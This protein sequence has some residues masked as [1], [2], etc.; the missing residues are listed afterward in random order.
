VAVV[1]GERQR[2]TATGLEILPVA[3]LRGFAADVLRAVGMPPADA[4]VSATA[5]TW[6]DLRALDAHGVISKLPQCVA[7]IRA[8][9]TAAAPEMEI[10]RETPGA[11]TLDA[12]TGWGQVAAARAMRLAIEKARDGGI[13]VVSVR[14]S[15]SAAA[16]GH[17][18]DLAARD[19]LIGIA[20]TNG[21]ALMPPWGGTTR[22]LGNQAHALAA[23]AG[24]HAPIVFDSATTRMSTGEIDG[25]HERR[26]ELPPDVLQDAAGRPTR[27]PGAWVEGLLLPAGGHR[28]FGLSVGLEVLTGV[29]AG[30]ERF[31]GDPRDV[32]YPFAFDEPQGVGHCLI[33]IDPGLTQPYEAFLER[34]DRLIDAIHASLPVPGGGPVRYPGERS[35]TLAAERERDGIPLTAERAATLREL[36]TSVGVA[37]G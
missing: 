30:G 23:P 26:E 34:V 22:V 32:G 20:A 13:G 37:L 6:A 2:M 27:D 24:R 11:A 29:L 14:N 31:A 21:P 1:E 3:R 18:A 7:R 15:S 8:G 12:R 4:E 5:M 25:Y 33:A 16:M 9:G 17:F 28:G 36:G 10:V 19:R 35:A